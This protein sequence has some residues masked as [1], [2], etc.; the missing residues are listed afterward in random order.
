MEEKDRYN[1]KLMSKDAT[2]Y[3]EFSQIKYPY[4][5]FNRYTRS[6][7]ET[8]RYYKQHG[9]WRGSAVV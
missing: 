2:C 4:V 1:S 9:D 8:L 6:N 5:N 3:S 7:I